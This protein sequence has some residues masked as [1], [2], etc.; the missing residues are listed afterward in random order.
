[1]KPITRPNGSVYRPR[2]MR[3]TFFGDDDEGVTAVVV[4]GTEDRAQALSQALLDARAYE[5]EYLDESDLVVDEAA[6]PE[7]RWYPRS[8]SGFED[9]A[10][11]YHYRNDP[12]RGA[13]A[14]VYRASERYDDEIP[15]P[16]PT[17]VP[18]F[19]SEPTDSANRLS[20]SPDHGSNVCGMP[21]PETY[22]A[23]LSGADRIG[24]AEI[25]TRQLPP[26]GPPI[27]LHRIVTIDGLQIKR[28]YRR[29]GTA[30]APVVEYRHVGDAPV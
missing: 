3:T 30:N 13:F 5:R 2:K 28:T 8:L 23:A 29:V 25:I 21:E 17:S 1:M 27:E 6:E 15:P 20:T 18:L 22:Q 24:A 10:P 19:D 9:G 16:D 11:R 12:E 14:L 26:G 4:W 7:A